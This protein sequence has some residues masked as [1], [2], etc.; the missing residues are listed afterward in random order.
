MNIEIVGASFNPPH[1]GHREIVSG[2]LAKYTADE[3]WL[4]PARK[5]AF[6]KSLTEGD[7]RLAM[8]QLFVQDFWEKP[9][10]IEK[11]ELE[12]ET[13]SYSYETLRHFEESQP[14]N[15]FAW[16]IGSDNIASFP[17]WYKYRELLEQ[18]TVYVYPR[19]NYPMENLLKG[20]VPISGVNEVAVSSTEVR[21][22]VMAGEDI[23]DLV[24]P[25]IAAY[26]DILLLMSTDRFQ[27]VPDKK[28]AAQREPIVKRAG[29]LLANHFIS[30]TQPQLLLDMDGVV[31][32]ADSLHDPRFTTLDII[33]TLQ[34]LEAQ[35][36]IIGPATGRGIHVTNYLREQGLQLSGPA[37]LEE[38]QKIVQHG[39]IEY[40]GH[41]NHRL[42][43]E[44]MR[45]VLEN[46]A[47]FLSRWHDVR[48]ATQKGKFAFCAGNYQWQGDCRS[49]FW[50]E[51]D[52]DTSH[53]AEIVSTIFEP[54]FR[55]IADR[56]GL[57]YDRDVAVNFYRM[58]PSEENGNLAIVG[59]KGTLD[60]KIIHKGIAAEKLEGTWGFVA[61]GFGDTPIAEVTKMRRG[62]VI[63][64]EGNLDMTKDAPEFLRSA[65]IVLRNPAEFTKALRHAAII[66]RSQK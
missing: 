7:H 27:Q 36:I 40:L 29:E 17:K 52:E 64:I 31:F 53:D 20:M 4:I 46:H 22:K 30:Q 21:A 42:F 1:N 32:H 2:L 28:E 61:D 26:I 24:G 11:Y 51:Y 44:N 5:H 63:G 16:V 59:I 62:V 39:A 3:V 19:P 34:L 35:G 66:L 49:S 47:G 56:H 25:A 15:T 8:L 9:V 37:I 50:F 13:T 45:G 12:K 38:G 10:R 14:S 58:Q 18:F 6:S 43:M 54:V 65:D 55:T 33:P 23:T 60:G 57:S 41:P 48:V